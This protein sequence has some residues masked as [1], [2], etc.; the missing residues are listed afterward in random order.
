MASGAVGALAG[1]A[2]FAQPP[3]VRSNRLPRPAVL[4]LCLLAA[5]GLQC[6]EATFRPV[7]VDGRLAVFD[8]PL[9]DTSVSELHEKEVA[10]DPPAFLRSCRKRCADTV[11]DYRCR[12]IKRERLND[13]LTPDQHIDVL[14]RES[15]YSVDMR[16]VKNPSAAQ[17][18]SYIAGRWADDGDELFLVE[19]AGLLGLLVPGGVKRSIH[20]P[21]AKAASRRSIDQFGFKNSL[22]LIIKY[23]DLAAG[24]P[25]YGLRYVGTGT[26]DGRRCYVIERF[27]PYTG[28]DG[29]YPD[30]RL[31]VYIDSEWLVPTGVFAYADDEKNELLGTYLL[32][33]VEFNAGLTDA[34]F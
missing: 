27:L 15:P 5:Y 13:A 9:A 17:R 22:D 16:W 20:G 32:I 18:V 28:V 12:F 33:D 10:A 23:C 25:E 4:G 30:R 21:A 34:D 2:P 24:S 1:G 3:K 11:H 7:V 29:P 31:V 19:P 6:H 14:F 26:L 8:A